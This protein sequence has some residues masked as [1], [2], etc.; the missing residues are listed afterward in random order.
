L[1]F[2]KSSY[3]KLKI[4]KKLKIKKKNS[5]TRVPCEVLEFLAKI[6]VELEFHELEYF[7]W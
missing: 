1:I 7:T 3:N 5:G 2:G 4:I 6:Q